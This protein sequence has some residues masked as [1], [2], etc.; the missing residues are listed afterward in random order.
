LWRSGRDADDWKVTDKAWLK[1]LEEKF[2][3]GAIS[4]EEFD[5]SL[6]EDGNGTS[7]SGGQGQ[8]KVAG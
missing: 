6:A 5:A 8:P 7:A 2:H 3:N 1:M 4:E